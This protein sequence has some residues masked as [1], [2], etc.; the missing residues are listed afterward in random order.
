MELGRY[1][2]YSAAAQLVVLGVMV[3]RFVSTLRTKPISV[4]LFT[5]VVMGP[6][7]GTLPA[8]AAVLALRAGLTVSHAG[9][10]GVASKLVVKYV[11]RRLL[12]AWVVMELLFYAYF[13]MKLQ[14]LSRRQ[15]LPPMVVAW[16]THRRKYLKY[17][18]ESLESVVNPKCVLPADPS[19]PLASRGLRKP[20]SSRAELHSS[21]ANLIDM[22]ISRT[23]SGEVPKRGSMP[24]VQ[25]AFFGNQGRRRRVP[26]VPAMDVSV[27]N[28]LRM[29]GGITAD[30]EMQLMAMKQA[31]IR[32]WFFEAPLEAIWRGNL[33]EWMLEY[34]FNSHSKDALLSSERADLEY[35]VQYVA[36]WVGM[37]MREGKNPDVRCMRLQQDPLPA[38]HRPLWIY[39]LTAHVAPWATGQLMKYFG[40]TKFRAGSLEYWHKPPKKMATQVELQ[41]LLAGKY[42]RGSQVVQVSTGASGTVRSTVEG[43]SVVVTVKTGTFQSGADV[44]IKDVGAGAPGKVACLNVTAPIVFCHGLGIGVLPYIQFAQELG[45]SG[46][47]L[48]VLDL[49]HISM[50]P[51]QDVPSSRE[52][53][54]CVVEMLSAFGHSNAHFV[55]H[56]FGSNV[57]A[58]VLKQKPAAVLSTSLLDPVCF[59]VMKADLLYNA[60]YKDHKNFVQ[61]VLQVCVF[62]ELFICHTL[63]RNFFWMDNNLMPH[64]MTVPIFIL[65]SGCDDIV[66]AHCVSGFLKAEVARREAMARAP[67]GGAT[68]VRQD[69]MDSTVSLQD[70][71]S[72]APLSQTPIRVLWEEKWIHCEFWNTRGGR[73]KVANGV[74]SIAAAAQEA[75][76]KRAFG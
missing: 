21:A 45:R 57:C 12:Q 35:C 49:P 48:F 18:F 36:D 1:R 60:L 64:E 54:M 66:P 24:K 25:S 75:K 69:S 9:G 70:V 32:S 34:F 20:C 68:L 53:V 37:E 65:L 62:Q 30:D 40:Y 16:G 50:S 8:C 56:S 26:S 76:N 43:S 58:W 72:V 52:V 71:Q 4:A 73:E 23:R 2:R 63:C 22:A 51:K 61:Y 59:L 74:L 38:V 3:A 17:V 39:A 6:I 42:K 11:L 44:S 15:H 5:S 13:R 33:E 19:A 10:M 28:L 27:E 47:E 55:G 14:R 67:A 29:K 46:A 41:G 7:Y 31:E